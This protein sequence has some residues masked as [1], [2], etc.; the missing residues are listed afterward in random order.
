MTVKTSHLGTGAFL[1]SE[2]AGHISRDTIVIASGSGI[3]LAGTVLG[4]ITVGGKYKPYDDDGGESDDGSRT[5]AAILLADVDATDAD[6][7]GVGIVR[8]AEVWTD[9]L[10]WGA[11]VTTETEKTNGLAD[12]AAKFVI[13]R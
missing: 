13:A 11:G 8:L 12:L 10:V 3:V 4:K 2:G 7:Q 5:A 1:K 9:R 6:A